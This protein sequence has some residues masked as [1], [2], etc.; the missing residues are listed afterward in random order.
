MT[1]SKPAIAYLTAGAGGMFCGSCIHDNTLARAL[2]QSGFD[3][4]LIPTYTPIRTDESD[5]SVHKV[6][7]G[8]INIY[9]QQKIPLFRHLPSIFDRFLDQ[10][11]LIRALTARAVDISLKELG[12]L[13]VSM[14]KGTSGYQRKEVNQLCHWLEHHAK[15]DIVVLTNILISGCVEKLRERL[16]VPILVTLQGDDIFLESLPEPYKSHAIDQI[17]SIVP[18]IDG[19]IVHSEYYANFMVDYIG[20]DRN[21]VHVTPLGIDTHDFSGVGQLSTLR[22]TLRATHTAG[23][24]SDQ[25]TIGYLARL[26]P[27]K[28]LH[29]LAEAFIELCKRESSIDYRLRIAGW[30]SPQNQKYVDEVFANLTAAGLADRFHYAGEVDRQRK[31]DF[32]SEL[33]LFSV[34][35]TYREPKGLF[36]LEAMACGVPVV[37]PAH[38]AFS[39]MIRATEGGLLCAPDQ[40]VDLADKLE[41]LAKD[42]PLR[43]QLGQQGRQHV[44]EYRN[45]TAM[46]TST[47]AVFD[48]YLKR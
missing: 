16:Q 13:T 27:E 35:T 11:W 32:L 10:P 46:A 3:V 48:H 28:G 21:K 23:Q 24:S 37:L 36:A 42:Q 5:V 2:N 7:F 29:Q 33:D 18:L 34:P 31:V 6:F 17:R 19:F 26:A 38:G 4:Q 30:L 44:L 8:G 39:E 47:I 43:R 41:L 40:P 15:P 25:I 9:L 45:E 14:L 1:H 22:A 12:A 20:I